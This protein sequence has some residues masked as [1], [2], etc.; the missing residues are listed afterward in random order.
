MV[1]ADGSHIQILTNEITVTDAT[2]N[3]DGVYTCQASNT[4]GTAQAQAVVDI[5]R[6]IQSFSVF[7]G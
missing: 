1:T 4:A 2:L 3:D 6:K 5:I 7:I